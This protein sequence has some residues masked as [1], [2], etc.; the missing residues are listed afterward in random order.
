MTKRRIT[1]TLFAVAVAVLGVA[2]APATAYAD[3]IVFT[4]EEDPAIIPGV[5]DFS[6]EADKITSSYV[7]DVTFSGNNFT[8][9]LVV[10]FNGYD[11]AGVPQ[12]NQVGT[13]TP[14]GE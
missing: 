13:N 1:N 9:T 7:E 6:L 10:T 11:L 12:P 14:A 4:V 8:A 5:T 2:L 3:P